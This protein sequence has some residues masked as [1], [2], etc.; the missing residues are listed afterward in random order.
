[1]NKLLK[2]LQEKL[3]QWQDEAAAFDHKLHERMTTLTLSFL[4]SVI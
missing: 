1:M 3:V 4:Y 2:K